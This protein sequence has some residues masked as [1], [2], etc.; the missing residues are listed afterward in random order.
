MRYGNL[1]RTVL[2]RAVPIAG[3][4][5]V[6]GQM[7]GQAVAHDAP[8]RDC[9]VMVTARYVP[10]AALRPVQP[11]AG[12]AEWKPLHLSF[13]VAG[14]AEGEKIT[15][16]LITVRGMTEKGGVI[17]AGVATGSPWLEKTLTVKVG[18]NAAGLLSSTA[19]LNGFGGVS[20][21]RVDSITYGNGRVWRP[22]GTES[23]HA[24][25]GSTLRASE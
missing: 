1:F 14:S 22:S 7:F 3:V 18:A 5:G 25:T 4:L 20:D 6:G 12:G 17:P 11:A 13:G 8:G 16:A 21:V 24:R 10:G 2:F 23:C 9:P 15:G 19:W